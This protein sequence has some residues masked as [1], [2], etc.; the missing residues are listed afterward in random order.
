MHGDGQRRQHEQL[1]LPRDCDVAGALRD[2]SGRSICAGELAEWRD[3][4]LF[5]Q[6]EWWLWAVALSRVQSSVR[7]HV[8]DRLDLGDLRRERQL[9]SKHQL[10]FPRHSESAAGHRVE[11]F[12]KHHDGRDQSEWRDSIFQRD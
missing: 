12:V 2:V 9:Q 5:S 10:L 1:Q 3:R 6:R 11:L 8:P 7:Q 4:I